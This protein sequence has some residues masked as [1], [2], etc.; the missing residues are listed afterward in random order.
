MVEA[1]GRS[2]YPTLRSRL[3]SEMV[4]TS[5]EFSSDEVISDD[6][7]IFG[8]SKEAC[9]KWFTDAMNSTDSRFD[10]TEIKTSCVEKKTR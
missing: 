3:N 8:E 10:A 4:L 2:I 5:D 9:R 6:D 1:A 7:A